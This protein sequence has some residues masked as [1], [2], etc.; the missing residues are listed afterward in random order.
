MIRAEEWAGLVPLSVLALVYWMR[1]KYVYNRV[2]AA[3]Y[4]PT[5][6]QLKTLVLVYPLWAFMEWTYGMQVARGD[7]LFV[8]ATVAGRTVVG[9]Y[10][11]IGVLND[12]F[13]ITLHQ[14][15]GFFLAL[16]ISYVWAVFGVLVF[17]REEGQ[18]EA[19]QNQTCQCDGAG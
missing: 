6:T 11:T 13:D 8:F 2:Q 14:L 1:D 10:T 4:R 18:V 12:G 15:Y 9:F 5:S 19:V 17:S 16:L 3:W 7:T